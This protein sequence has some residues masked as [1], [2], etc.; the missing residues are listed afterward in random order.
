MGEP[1][2]DGDVI[3]G[4]SRHCSDIHQSARFVAQSNNHGQ[5]ELWDIETGEMKWV[6]GEKL[7]A[8]VGRVK[9]E[10]VGF[11]KDELHVYVHG[12]LSAY[13]LAGELLREAIMEP[14][15]LVRPTGDRQYL[16]IGGEEETVIVNLETYVRK[17]YDYSMKLAV[18]KVA[19]G[20]SADKKK[21]LLGNGGKCVVVDIESGEAS[22]EYEGPALEDVLRT[23]GVNH[24]ITNPLDLTRQIEINTLKRNGT[25][26]EALLLPDGKRLVLLFG[27]YTQGLSASEY[28][29]RMECID[30]EAN[31]KLLWENFSKGPGRNLRLCN[32]GRM[33]RFCEI[34]EH[35]QKLVRLDVISGLVMQ[36]D[37]FSI[38][39]KRPYFSPAV[40]ELP[41]EY[42][43]LSPDES[44][45]VF[46]FEEP[47]IF[48]AEGTGGMMP[49]FVKKEVVTAV[50]FSADSEI[51]LTHSAQGVGRVFRH[52]TE[53]GRGIL[54]KPL[55]WFVFIT[56]L[57]WS[58]IGA[59]A[60]W[61]LSQRR[62]RKK[63]SMPIWY[64]GLALIAS[65]RL[66]YMLTDNMADWVEFSAAQPWER[67][68][69]I[70]LTMMLGQMLLTGFCLYFLIRGEEWVR[71]ISVTLCLAG[72]LYY[73]FLA[74]VSLGFFQTLMQGIVRTWWGT[75]LLM[76]TDALHSHI[77]LHWT[78]YTI[79]VVILLGRGCREWM[80]RFPSPQEL[81]ADL[82]PVTQGW[83]QY[84][85]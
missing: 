82:S 7:D 68:D 14:M 48:S 10:Y 4:G 6:K 63:V 41:Q 12:K 17:K 33:V 55:G 83:G 58:G 44:Q 50:K 80:N 3:W 36:Q 8:N 76:D 24:A 2:D 84:R 15:S 72:V 49:L 5:V 37:E 23:V 59:K 57:I 30:L 73:M 74:L 28:A 31:G 9:V 18:G 77:L 34:T 27:E 42:C 53:S 60:L 61:N 85:T 70:Y 47:W 69:V 78:G 26:T 46:F 81:E 16:A 62:G 54:H 65:L 43:T 79:L 25:P 1:L 38:V 21:L 13:N 35:G 20:L 52:M 39:R 75:P 19:V 66:A 32:G 56:W 22:Y 40:R 29:S 64:A 67:I 45:I 51:A 71:R 11:L